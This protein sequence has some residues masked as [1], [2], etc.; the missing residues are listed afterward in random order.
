MSDLIKREDAIKV[1]T[2]VLFDEP[3]YLN[4]IEKCETFARKTLESIPSAEP[5]PV[6]TEEVREAIMRLTMCARHEC[7][8]CKLSNNEDDCYEIATKRMHILV[9]AFDK[10]KKEWIPCSERLPENIRPVL[11]TWK[12]NDPASYYQYIVGKHF[13]GT[14]HY[15]RGKWYWY[16]SV[17]EDLLAEYGKC[18][19][20]EFDEAIEAVAWMPLPEPWEGE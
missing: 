1:L 9:D 16:S 4:S 14:A 19:T 3:P 8:I 20:E 11:V 17:T 10:P 6:L 7:A 2:E 5:K 18:E 12:N 13:I 15:H